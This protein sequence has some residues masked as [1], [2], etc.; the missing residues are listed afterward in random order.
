MAPAFQ[1]LLGALRTAAKS[2]PR[3]HEV[4]VKDLCA[5]YGA[6]AAAT[7]TYMV[8]KNFHELYQELKAKDGIHFSIKGHMNLDDNLAS[9][10]ENRTVV[11]TE[12]SSVDAPPCE[13][14]QAESLPIF[15]GFTVEEEDFLTTLCESGNADVIFLIGL[16]DKQR[17]V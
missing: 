15:E 12:H 10:Y 8:R 17:R 9:G 4:H 16:I 3:P 7:T 11:F 5:L 2:R 6:P 1:K 13:P 14:P